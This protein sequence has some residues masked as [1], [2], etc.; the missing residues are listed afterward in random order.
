MRVLGDGGTLP[1]H[2]GATVGRGGGGVGRRQDHEDGGRNL[3]VDLAGEFDVV[4]PVE[5]TSVNGVDFVRHGMS[6]A[7]GEVSGLPGVVRCSWEKRAPGRGSP[8]SGRNTG[9]GSE[10][11]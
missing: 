6:P 4:A 1:R 5:A 3:V 9:I 10:N 8:A 2:P 11:P 7:A